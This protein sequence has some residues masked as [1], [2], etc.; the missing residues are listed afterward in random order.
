MGIKG[1]VF[2]RKCYDKISLIE[3]GTHIPGCEKHAVKEGIWKQ[4]RLNISVSGSYH[5]KNAYITLHGNITQPNVKNR[6]WAID[7]FEECP[8][9][10]YRI[11]TQPTRFKSCQLVSNDDKV[12]WKQADEQETCQCANNIKE[13]FS[14]KDRLLKLCEK[15]NGRQRCCQFNVNNGK[16]GSAFVNFQVEWNKNNTIALIWNCIRFNGC[17]M[18]NIEIDIRY[19]EHVITKNIPIEEHICGEIFHNKIDEIFPWSSQLN[20]KITA[21]IG[22]QKHSINVT[23]YSYPEIPELVNSTM[24]IIDEQNDTIRFQINITERTHQ[25][26]NTHKYMFIVIADPEEIDANKNFM[27]QRNVLSEI[28]NRTCCIKVIAEINLSNFNREL[29]DYTIGN[30]SAGSSHVLNDTIHNYPLKRRPSEIIIILINEY[31]NKYSSKLYSHP[32]QKVKHFEP[33]PDSRTK[34]EKDDKVIYV[35]LFTLFVVCVI[36]MVIIIFIIYKRKNDRG[37]SDVQFMTMDDLWLHEVDENDSSVMNVPSDKKGADATLSHGLPETRNFPEQSDIIQSKLIKLSEF[38]EYMKRSLEY[39]E[40]ERQHELFPRGRT[41]PCK[42]G[43]LEVNKHKNRY[44]N[45]ITYDHSRVVL[46]KTADDEYSDYINASYVHG[47]KIANAYIATQG[48]KKE[49][50]KDFWRMIWQENV[51]Y[52]VMI[53]NIFGNGK[54]EIHQYWPTEGDINF[55]D[56]VVQIQSVIEFAEFD[57]R[58]F[59]LTHEYETRKLEQIHFTAWSDQGIPLYSH[60]LLSFVEKVAKIPLTSTSPV[61]VHCSAGVGRT[62]TI[63][64]IDICL[65]MA[66]EEKSV[67]FLHTLQKLRQQRPNMVD[68]EEQ[69]K[70]AHLVVLDYYFGLRTSI[71]CDQLDEQLEEILNNPDKLRI[72]F[73]YLENCRWVD[74]AMKSVGEIADNYII[75]SEKIDLDILFQKDVM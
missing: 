74:E 61:V 56:I 1:K 31:K 18:K 40:L 19:V 71:P 51:N 60:T 64:L 53:G 25:K 5:Q 52:I 48:P 30:G 16:A 28:V 37:H 46:A 32:L 69:Y 59:Y 8:E 3:N 7:Y 2:L 41:Q 33:T 62:G 9:L 73:D 22:G 42:Y 58:I 49:T 27:E 24:S 68:N 4:V 34:E 44:E 17:S 15:T 43:S 67:D 26:P 47:Y 55:G 11:S 14:I 13:P 57:Q 35:I 23:E 50:T 29:I 75:P 45:L 65:R 21:S 10:E 54:E 39:R 72:Q 66:A 12:E 6:F 20:I 63:L 70:L 38:E 36:G